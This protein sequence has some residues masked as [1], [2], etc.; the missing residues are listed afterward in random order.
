MAFIIWRSTKVVM[1]APDDGNDI[2]QIVAGGSKGENS[3]GG[4]S[5]PSLSSFVPESPDPTHS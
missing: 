5:A 2:P 4:R 3:Q 1:P